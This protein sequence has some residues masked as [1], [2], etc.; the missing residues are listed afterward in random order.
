MDGEIKPYIAAKLLHP[1]KDVDF[2]FLLGDGHVYGGYVN[3][4]LSA[5]HRYNVFLRAYSVDKVS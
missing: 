3:T 4:P 5:G 2:M 1:D